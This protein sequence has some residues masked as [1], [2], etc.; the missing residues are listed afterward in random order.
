MVSG[1]SGVGKGSVIQGVLRRLDGLRLSIST[2][3]RKQ[4][5]GE[6]EGVDYNFVTR[7]EFDRI[8]AEGGFLESAEVYGELYGTPLMPLERLLESGLDVLL[9]IDI[10]GASSVRQ[11]L[12]DAVTIFIDPPSSEAL[13]E[14]LTARGADAPEVIS[15]RVAEAQREQAAGADFDYRIV[16]DSLDAAVSEAADIIA[17]RRK[18]SD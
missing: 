9:E 11:R 16:N 4:R 7:N 17:N 6:R 12:P 1:P 15:R 3:T 14:R 18:E 8:R 5:P 2:T 13:F 10:Q